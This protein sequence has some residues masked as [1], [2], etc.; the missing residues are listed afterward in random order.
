[1]SL[2]LM[3]SSS[4]NLP[5]GPQKTYAQFAITLFKNEFDRSDTFKQK[6]EKLF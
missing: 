5:D 1:M 2:T 4:T 3:G 6:V